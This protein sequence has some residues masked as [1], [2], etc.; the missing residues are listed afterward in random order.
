MKIVVVV[1]DPG[2]RGLH[3]PELRPEVAVWW[4]RLAADVAVTAVGLTG[5][6]F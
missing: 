2:G 6:G 3:Q 1:W 5:A 4:A